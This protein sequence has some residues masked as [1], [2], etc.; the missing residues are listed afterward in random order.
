MFGQSGLTRTVMSEYR[1]KISGAHIYID[2]IDGPGLA[3]DVALI[4]S[5]KIFIYQIFGRDY[6]HT[7]NYFNLK[8]VY[9]Q[10]KRQK[11]ENTWYDY[12]YEETYQ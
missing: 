2:I 1:D 5:A 10:M 8:E 7:E 9:S 6:S 3:A 4:I 11:R 12:M